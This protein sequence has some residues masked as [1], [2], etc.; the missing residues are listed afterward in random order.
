LSLLSEGESAREIGSELY[1]SQATI[2]NHIRALLGDA[3]ST[4]GPGQ[5]QGVQDPLKLTRASFSAHVCML[6][7]QVDQFLPDRWL[8]RIRSLRPFPDSVSRYV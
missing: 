6:G 3:L 7:L 8:T 1:L 4:G 5:G 2:R